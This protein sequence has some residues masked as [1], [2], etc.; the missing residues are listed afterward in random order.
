IGERGERVVDRRPCSA[1][2]GHVVVIFI[3]GLEERRVNDPDEGPR[4]LV[5][6]PRA[7]T[8]FHA[9]STEQP[10]GGAPRASGEENRIARVSADGGNETFAFGVGEVLRDW[11][12]QLPVLAYRDICE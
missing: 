4:V 10:E 8:D 7:V 5:D 3:R 12:A 2:N 9:G 1:P 11:A 6:Q